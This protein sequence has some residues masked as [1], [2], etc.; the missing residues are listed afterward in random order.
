MWR[1]LRSSSPASL[2]G[3]LPAVAHEECLQHKAST[4]A[5]ADQR[6]G[7]HTADRVAGWRVWCTHPAGSRASAPRTRCQMAARLR[8]AT[9]PPS[10]KAMTCSFR[11]ASTSSSVSSTTA[12]T[13]SFIAVELRTLPSSRSCAGATSS[14]SGSA[15]PQWHC[16]CRAAGDGGRD[17]AAR[18][19]PNA[20]GPPDAQPPAL[21]Y[22]HNDIIN[23][24]DDDELPFH[25][26]S[27]R[28]GADACAATD[29]R[30]AA[31]RDAQALPAAGF[32]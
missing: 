10:A 31:A 20:H 16:T 19:V 27:S 28:G 9:R 14:T 3:W 5:G 1:S 30:G 23:Y 24:S 7:E 11:M 25:A 22:C 26:E 13:L 21:P 29:A 12:L 4:A 32:G 18:G 15:K 17:H 6:R 2:A 8:K